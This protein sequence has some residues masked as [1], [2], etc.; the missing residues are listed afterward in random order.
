MKLKTA[1]F[2]RTLRHLFGAISTIAIGLG[3][4]VRPDNAEAQPLP[5]SAVLLSSRAKSFVNERWNSASFT[6]GIAIVA[7]TKDTPTSRAA[8]MEVLHSNRKKLTPDEMRIFLGEATRLAK[9]TSLDETNSAFAVSVMAN[10]TLT[11]KDQGQLSEAESKQEAGFLVATATDSRHNAQL[12]SS[13]IVALGIL[14]VTEARGTL[15]ELLTN[16]AVELARP[17]CLSL[18]RVDGDSAIPDLADTMKKTSDARLFGTAAFALGQLKKREC[19]AAL[20]ENLGR[21]PGSGACDAALVDMDD[22]IYSILKDPLDENLSA[23]V[24]ATRYLWRD[25][26]REIYIPLLR[27]LLSTAPLAARKAAVERL[28]DSASCLD[29]GSEKRELILVS[30]AIGEQPELNE[31]QKR[32]KN[33]LSASVVMPSTNGAVHIPTI[34][35]GGEQK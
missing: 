22:V 26:Q 7:D 13:A 30:Q 10:I 19:V 35:K 32:I 25:G 28:L 3:A 17:A 4:F 11:M 29:F 12:R 20:V 27:N 2:V 31:Y 24:Q 15:R 21:F 18:M 5:N 23:A 1:K 34:L 9:D 8:A 16:S 33:R 14:K 6:N